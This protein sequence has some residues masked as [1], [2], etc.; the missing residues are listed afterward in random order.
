MPLFI[1]QTGTIGII[2]DGIT[3]NVTG[4]IFLS[5]L[6]LLI[7][8]MLLF[9]LFRLPIEATTILA[10]PMILVFMSYYSDFMAIGG[11]VLIYLG[12]I[13]AKNFFIK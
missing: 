2:L 5:L 4:S 6:G 9:M 12:L 10:L 3:R 11:A 7:I 8:I 13:V 1:N